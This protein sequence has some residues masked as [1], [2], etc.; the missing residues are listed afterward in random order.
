[1]PKLLSGSTLRAGGSGEYIKLPG[2]QPQLPATDTTT[3]GYTLVT[4]SLLRTTYRSSL[5]NLEMNLGEIWSNLP[6]G[7]IT[8][9]GT[10]TGFITV[11]SSIESAGTDTGSLVVGGGVGIGGSLWTNNDIHVNSL[12]IGQGWQG[13]NNIVIQGTAT[14]QISEFNDGQSSIVIGYDA[15]MGLTTSY[16]NIAI[17]NNALSSGTELSNSIAIGDN[18]LKSIGTIRAILAADI[19]NITQESPVVVAAVDHNLTSG[20]QVVITDLSGS[21]ELDNIV[22]YI[23]VL[24]PST[25]ALYTDDILSVP[26]DG[27]AFT[28]Y[29]GGGKL[30]RLVTNFSQN[31]AI[32]VDAGSS[33]IEGEQNFFFCVNSAKTLTTGSYNMFFGHDVG[34]NMITGNANISI[35]GDNLVDGL[36]NQV[37]IGSVFYFNGS[38]YTQFNSDVGMGLGT[39]A[40]SAAYVTWAP[41]Q[42]YQSGQYV[43]YSDSYFLTIRDHIA[44]SLFGGTEPPNPGDLPYFQQIDVLPMQGAMSVYGGLGISDNALFGGR[45]HLLS[46]E[47]SISSSTGALIVDGGAGIVKD[48]YVHGTIIPS[49]GTGNKGIVFPSNPGPGT[50]DGA[51]IQYYILPEGTGEDTIL[52][53]NVSDNLGDCI[54]LSASGTVLVT[55]DLTSTSID[56]GALQ[57]RGGIGVAKDVYVGGVMKVDGLI[58]GDITNAQNID[59]GAAGS[60]LYQTETNLT[61]KLD[62]GSN[63]YTL[64]SDGSNPY[65]ADP[66]TLASSSADTAQKVFVN[67]VVPGVTYYLGLTELTGDN[68]PIDSDTDLSY[69]TTST[70]SGDY[71]TTGTSILNVPGSVYSVDGNKDLDYILYTPKYT[72]GAAPHDNPRPGDTWVDT[73]NSAFYQWIIDGNNAYWLQIAII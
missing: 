67:D 55:R 48:L 42:S 56:T 27:T 18:A 31:T 8:L 46:S 53:L 44:G 29:I 58:T 11:A 47:T 28:P 54:Y 60:L 39:T 22:C 62:I 49:V 57:V 59:G 45:V 17:G 1:M 20:I 51:R 68:S 64:V 40:T 63:G 41:G 4:D 14:N 65:W 13:L 71:F 73:D 72:V 34:N 32:G 24:T 15:L 37:N 2:A 50:G 7:K 66:A 5:G 9:I 12:T 36:D 43:S 30:K 33:L 26:I 21:N 38:G 25:V 16:K 69:V 70:I 10:G 35:G 6:D 23:Q 61:G 52:E 19:S 3:T